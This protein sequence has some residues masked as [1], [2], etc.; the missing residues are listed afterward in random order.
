MAPTA[1]TK[2]RAYFRK[3]ME[4]PEVVP[5]IGGV[6]AVF[7]RRSPDKETLNED[8]AALIPLDAQTAVLVVADGLGGEAAG[9][10]ASQLSIRALR[11]SIESAAG[12]GMMLRSAILNG[13]ENANLAVQKLGIGAATTMAAVELHADTVRPYHVGDSMILLVGQRGLI[14]MQSL[15]HSPVGYAV[16]AG[17]INEKEA[18]HHEDRHLVSNVIGSPDMRIEIGS[19]IKLAQHDTLL[20]ASDGLFDNLRIDEIIQRLRKG[21]LHT[22]AQRLSEDAL[23]RMSKPV[24]SKPSKPDDL[25]LIVFR[26]VLSSQDQ[27]SD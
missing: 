4:Q 19:S 6:A 8:A 12:Q 15:S 5:L 13:F 3:D 16:E 11:R 10:Q 17:V 22:A 24:E 18:M 21:P 14:K 23:N 25:T 26:P 2:V 9:E 7:S 1:E 27:L 20:L